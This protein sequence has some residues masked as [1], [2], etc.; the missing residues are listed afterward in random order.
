MESKIIISDI[1]RKAWQNLKSQ[2]WI[3]IG[4]MIG[5]TIVSFTLSFIT[6]PLQT[7]MTGIIIS[8]LISI[9]ISLI[10]GMG[11]IK[12]IFQTLDGIEPQFSAYGQ[13]ARKIVNYF[14]AQII[15]SFLMSIGFIV[16][17]IPGIYIALRLQ[18]VGAFIIEEDAGIMDS[19]KR[20]WDITRDQVM[21]LFV[22]WLAAFAIMIIGAILFLVGI[23]VAIPLVYLMWADIFRK[24]NSPLQVIEEL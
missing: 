20:S 12:N 14:C 19:I 22:F 7:S 9:I 23:F 16:F 17:I 2:M 5:I 21:P 11:Y 24:L 13:Q 18:F 3:L 15:S 4:L 8:N 10:F 1:T 6:L